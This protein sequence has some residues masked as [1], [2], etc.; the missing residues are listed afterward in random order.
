MKGASTGGQM[1]KIARRK[2]H[3]LGLLK[4]FRAYELPPGARL[5]QGRSPKL[6][7]ENNTASIYLKDFRLTDCHLEH[8]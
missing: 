6:R 3:C 7:A 1:A 4:D 8:V 2:Q 5:T